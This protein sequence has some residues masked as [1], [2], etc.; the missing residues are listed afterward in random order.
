MNTFD[1]KV[2]RLYSVAA[3]DYGMSLTSRNPKVYSLQCSASNLGL[4]CVKRIISVDEARA[5]D[6][7]KWNS[8]ASTVTTPDSYTL[9]DEP[10]RTYSDNG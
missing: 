6:N 3:E 8:L 4:H 1:H 2:I 9:S 5:R 7:D 10:V